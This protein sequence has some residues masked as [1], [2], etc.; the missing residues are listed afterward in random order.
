MPLPTTTTRF[1]G[2]ASPFVGVDENKRVEAWLA[3]ERNAMGENAD[4]DDVSKRRHNPNATLRHLEDSQRY[5]MM[6]GL[7]R[8]L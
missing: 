1:L 4:V 7:L 8:S 5:I 6:K 2:L 3:A